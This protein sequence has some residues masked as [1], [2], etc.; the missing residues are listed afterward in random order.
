MQD[1]EFA[2]M[3]DLQDQDELRMRAA[4]REEQAAYADFIA[5]MDMDD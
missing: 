1:R 4:M 3:D 2:Q 5:S